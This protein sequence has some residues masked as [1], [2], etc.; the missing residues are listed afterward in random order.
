MG[1][2][3]VITVHTVAI[4][5]STF[6]IALMARQQGR[7]GPTSAGGETNALVLKVSVQLQR[8]EGRGAGGSAHK[9]IQ[10]MILLGVDVLPLHSNAHW[11]AVSY[12]MGWMPSTGDTLLVGE[13]SLRS[14][15]Q[16]GRGRSI[17]YTLVLVEQYGL[18]TSRGATINIQCCVQSEE[19]DQCVLFSTKTVGS[20]N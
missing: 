2:P 17:G 9:D 5:Q 15:A 10:Y 7:R 16:F 20:Y 19:G 1:E 11:R 13:A 6:I 18:I 8:I 12:R 14:S 4:Y 3:A